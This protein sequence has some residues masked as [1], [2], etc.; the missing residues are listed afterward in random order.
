M[1]CRT[2]GMVREDSA[3]LVARM[4]FLKPGGH[5]SNIRLCSSHGMVECTARIRSGHTGS[6]F[7]HKRLRLA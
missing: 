5:A 7:T 4:T 1:T 3:M 6:F 2:S